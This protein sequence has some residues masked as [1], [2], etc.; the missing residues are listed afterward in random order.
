MSKPLDKQIKELV[1]KVTKALEKAVNSKS[2]YTSIGRDVSA[3]IKKRTR[4]GFG[5]KENASKQYNLKEAG[6]SKKYTKIREKF[7]K[8][9]S[10]DTT[11]KKQNL[12]ATGQLLDSITSIPSAGSVKI[13]LKSDRGN[14]LDG[15]P[16]K[17]NNFKI[18]SGQKEKGREFLNLS[19]A[20]KNEIKRKLERIIQDTIKRLK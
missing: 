11:P 4:I 16:S 5:V 7:K 13:T 15:K 3:Q 19:S 12:T 1:D 9:L 18:A 20:E 6:R 14:G 8:N 10:K 17:T 2:L